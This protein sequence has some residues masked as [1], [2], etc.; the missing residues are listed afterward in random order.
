MSDNRTPQ[1]R[2]WSKVD[3]TASCWIWIASTNWLGYGQFKLD[4]RMCR[5]HRVA[6]EWANGQVPHGA[7]LDHLCRNRACV[8]PA[9]LEPVTHAENV[10]RG[11]T[12][13]KSGAAKLAK[14]HCPKG[15][16]YG[17][18][19]VNKSGHRICRTCAID[20]S[21]A[22]KARIRAEKVERTVPCE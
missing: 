2:F 14:T 16:T 21:R 17:D 10:R 1:E 20:Y 11:E 9:H 18:A 15:H 8:N 22:Q 3:K 6:Y 19:Y 12:G 13:K 5:S 4:G 7:D